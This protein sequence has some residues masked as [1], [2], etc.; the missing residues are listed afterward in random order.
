MLVTAMLPRPRAGSAALALLASAL[1]ATAAPVAALD[2]A[3]KLGLTPIGHDGAFFELTLAPGET[4]TL[5]VEVANFG[6]EQVDARTYAA[7]VYSIINGGFG[8]DLHG[9][10]SSGTTLWLSYPEQVVTLT[11]QDAI[12]V[13][14]TVTVPAATPPGEYVASL[15]VENVEPFRGSG[16][17]AIDQVNRSAI[18]VAIDV[19]GPRAPALEIGEAGHHVAGT[20][21]VITFVVDNPGNVHLRPA[22]D[23]AVF[24]ASG[25]EVGAGP[26]VMDS[27]YAGTGTLFEAPLPT[28]LP[29]GDY[30]AVLRLADEATG[31]ADETDCLSF[32]V[33]PAPTEAANPAS[34]PLPAWL[35]STD[36]IRTAAPLVLLGLV[37]VLAML[38]SVIVRRRRRRQSAA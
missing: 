22:G 11:A 37:L 3:P 13:D 29:E 30:C 24:D 28:L 38:V 34:A 19:P 17:V 36:V 7:D 12:V 15:V 9:E 2:E 14:F 27:V 6:A 18:A 32:R 21:S 1:L 8:A 26:A 23:F 10:P 33:G 5:S 16:S 35:P 4:T 31:A 20:Q 25:Q